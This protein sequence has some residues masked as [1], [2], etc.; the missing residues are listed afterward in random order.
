MAH[1]KRKR[2]KRSVKC[3]MCTQYRWYGNNSGR[4]KPKYAARLK[5]VVTVDG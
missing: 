1:F 3:T 5:E 4:M 2:S